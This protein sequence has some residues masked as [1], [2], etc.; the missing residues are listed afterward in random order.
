MAGL[1]GILARFALRLLFVALATVF[2]LSLL[3]ALGVV[4]LVW[5]LRVL[6]ARLTGRPMAPWVVR[7]DPRAGW[8]VAERWTV[9]RGGGPLRPAPNATDVEVRELPPGQ[10]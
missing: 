3:A 7:V 5:G 8:R 1:P 4:A 2:V 10:P 6:W 9:R